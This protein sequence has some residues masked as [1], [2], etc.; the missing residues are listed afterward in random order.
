MN[1]TGQCA[2]SNGT[3]SGVDAYNEPYRPQIHFSPSVNFMNDPNGMFRHPGNGL[4]HLYYQYNPTAP[5]AGN[6]HWGHA[7]SEDLW[8]WTNHPPAISPDKPGDGIFT[9]SAVVDVNNS[10]G[11]F[12]AS[13]A[14]EDRI[15]AIYTLNNARETQEIAFST[16]GGYTFTKYANNPVID[17]NT[18]Q[19]RDP[20]VH[21]DVQT[22]H[23]VMT[24]SLP[25]VYEILFFSSP[26]LKSW[27]ELSRFKVSGLLGFQY[28][29]PGLFQVPTVGGPND[30]TKTWVLW[31]SI[32]PGAPLG[33]SAMQYF[34]G[35]W[36]GT[37]FTPHDNAARIIDFGK[38][39]Y[40]AQTFFEVGN[41]NTTTAIGWASNWQYTNDV[42]T[43]PW[44]STM[45]VARQLSLRYVRYNPMYSNY[46]LVQTPIST[47]RIEVGSFLNISTPTSES[48]SI[49][50]AG[51]DGA[52]DIQASFL[53]PG[54]SGVELRIGASGNQ[55]LK[56]G[57]AFGDPVTV[58]VDRRF[59]GRSW[60]DGNVF[61]ADRYSGM[62][63]PNKRDDGSTHFSL[64]VIV[65]RSLVEV[66]ANDGEASSV[67]NV[68]W[69]NDALPEKLD[70]VLGN[71][72]VI[73]ESLVVQKL[74]GTWNCSV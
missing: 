57:A 16:D 24:V 7:T 68:F 71:Q 18:S 55:V 41:A 63:M 33:G 42:P 15:V 25:Q 13:V 74:R 39:F 73:M 54:G 12:N 20:K 47:A 35:D 65:D 9:G 66:F 40:A 5:V 34:F 46:V 50:F 62:V 6:Q 67:S 22:S 26:D 11:F 52:V 21:W 61:F 32:N 49:D 43:T 14:P 1:L 8:T 17:L 69:D 19:F 64:H 59:A 31:I 2:S 37:T 36:N 56:I 53:L 3:D 44:R 10:S 4:W 27:T 30:G 58:Y 45:T 23:W 60:A 29:C 72:Q 70:I 48:H 38:D 51:W 28:E